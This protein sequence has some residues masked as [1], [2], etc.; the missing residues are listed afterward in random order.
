MIDPLA[1][2]RSTFKLLPLVVTDVWATNFANWVS[3]R[4][5]S[6][7]SLPG[8]QGPGL[9][10]TFDKATF[11]TELEALEDTTDEEEGAI[12]FAEAWETAML[13]SIAAV[14]VG[15]SIGAPTTF[16]TW[17]AISSTVIDAPSLAA[18]KAK[19]IE[20]KDAPKVGDADLSDFPP[21]F[22]DAFLLLTI[23]TTG[24]DSDGPPNPLVDPARPVA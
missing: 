2:W 20:L 7:M 24:V 10:F 22:R 15:T 18:G 1:T 11:I 17:S 9:T 6:K 21:F 12:N 23:T 14:A 19:I 13:S 16:T 5:T 4:V 3:D 8:L